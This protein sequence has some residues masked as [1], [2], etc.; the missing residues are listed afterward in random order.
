MRVSEV[1]STA[2]LPERGLR[3]PF[4]DGR[5]RFPALGPVV[6]RLSVHFELCVGRCAASHDGAATHDLVEAAERGSIV[7]RVLNHLV[8]PARKRHLAWARL[9]DEVP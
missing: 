5:K 4:V 1:V 2:I 8:E 3:Q 9:I 6:A 7:R